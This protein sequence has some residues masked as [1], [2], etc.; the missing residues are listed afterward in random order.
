MHIAA[1]VLLAIVLGACAGPQVGPTES[2]PTAVPS[3][4]D[5]TTAGTGLVDSL[6]Q[7][8][9]GMP[10]TKLSLTLQG[11]A[12]PRVFLKALGRLGKTPPETELALAF[13]SG[14]ALYAMRVDGTSGSEIFQALME[15]AGYP[16]ELSPLPTIS[17]GGKQVTKLASAVGPYLYTTD[18]ALYY[19]EARDDGTAA[20]VLEELP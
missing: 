8:F 5:P 6:P 17:I 2:P 15:Q 9:N 20:I 11:R 7:A 4:P 16:P 1:V 14:A 18:D 3:T 13:G 12:T 10:T 19:V